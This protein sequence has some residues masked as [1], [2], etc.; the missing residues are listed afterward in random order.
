MVYALNKLQNSVI[1]LKYHEL[2]DSFIHGVVQRMTG[3]Q[4]GDY[5]YDEVLPNTGNPRNKSCTMIYQ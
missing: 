3:K 4:I 1:K 2:I 5:M